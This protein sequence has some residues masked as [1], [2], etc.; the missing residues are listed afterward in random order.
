MGTLSSKVYIWMPNLAYRGLSNMQIYFLGCDGFYPKIMVKP[1]SLRVPERITLSF[2]CTVLRQLGP[3]IWQ[4]PGDTSPVSIDSKVA[5]STR[6]EVMVIPSHNSTAMT[7]LLTV[8]YPLFS[9]DNGTWTCSH[10]GQESAQVSLHLFS[11]PSDPTPTIYPKNGTRIALHQ[12]ESHMF[13]CVAHHAYPPVTLLWV[14][15]SGPEATYDMLPP[16]HVKSPDGTSATIVSLMLTPANQNSVF[17]C[18]A[19]HPL[20]K[21]TVYKTVLHYR[22]VFK[23]HPNYR[24]C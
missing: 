3:V 23:K 17:T 2:S 7:Y 11:K 4:R 21:K 10:F 1:K 9:R 16:S 22:V 24:K 12:L 8:I 20:Y 14:K 6:Y 13:Q 18:V 5:D 15:V 19:I